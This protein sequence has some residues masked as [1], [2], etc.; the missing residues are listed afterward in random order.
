MTGRYDAEGGLFQVKSRQFMA[1]VVQELTTA[2]SLSVG[3][4][5]GYRHRNQTLTGLRA[6]VNLSQMD[7]APLGWQMFMVFGSSAFLSMPAE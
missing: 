7:A 6:T 2:G 1:G 4:S 5:Q 3:P